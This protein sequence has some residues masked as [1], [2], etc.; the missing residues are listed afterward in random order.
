MASTLAKLT[1]ETIVSQVKNNMG[2]C[3]EIIISG[4]GAYNKSIVSNIKIDMEENF[5]KDIIVCTTKN[6]GFNPKTI[7]A[8]LFAWLAMCKI[9]S[10]K[11]DYRSITGSSNIKTIGKIY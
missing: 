8:G 5:G 4:G 11:L 10:T 1:S 2:N 3:E 9:S 7:E 6:Y